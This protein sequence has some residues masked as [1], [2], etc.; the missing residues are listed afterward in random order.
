MLGVPRVVRASAEPP[1]AEGKLSRRELR[2]QDGP[3]LIQPFDDR[4]VVVEFLVLEGCRPPGRLVPPGGDDVFGSPGDTVQQAPVAPP[5]E[6]RIDR[7]RLLESPLRGEGDDA[8]E[9]GVVA[10]ETIQVHRRELDG[11]DLAGFDQPREM[12]QRPES[13]LLEVGRASYS[14]GHTGSKRPL[15]WVYDHPRDQWVEVH[16]WRDAIVDLDV[17]DL[18]E[19]CEAFVDA[20]DHRLLFLVGELQAGEPGGFPDHLDGDSLGALLLDPPPQ[21]AGKEH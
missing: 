16:R 10:L 18:V 12:G 15:G 4:G 9:D 5:G 3:G 11:A 7:P 13:H 21:K 6:L 1:V 20:L 8:V 19:A 14:V 17:T 2:D